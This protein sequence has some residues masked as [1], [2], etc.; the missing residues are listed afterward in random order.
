MTDSTTPVEVPLPRP[1]Y[2]PELVAGLAALRKVVPP[3]GYQIHELTG[4]TVPSPAG[5]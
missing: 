3:L 5:R 4:K 1:P 2:D